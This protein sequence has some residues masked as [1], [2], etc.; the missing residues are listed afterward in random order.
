[1]EMLVTSEYCVIYNGYILGL[2]I[3]TTIQVWTKFCF[4]LYAQYISLK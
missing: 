2:P 3:K 1:M 4:Y